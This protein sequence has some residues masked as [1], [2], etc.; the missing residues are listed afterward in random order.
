MNDEIFTFRTLQKSMGFFVGSN[1]WKF[2]VSTKKETY[3]MFHGPFV[4][5]RFR[6]Q[7]RPLGCCFFLKFEVCIALAS[8]LEVALEDVC[9]GKDDQDQGT[10]R[11]RE[12][13]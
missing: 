10:K 2:Q 4:Y 13:G 8:D 9:A 3:P 5:G 6:V 12:E 7:L 11:D 1:G